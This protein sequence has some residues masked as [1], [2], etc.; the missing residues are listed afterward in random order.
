M[1]NDELKPNQLVKTVYLNSPVMQIDQFNFSD[2]C[3]VI[4]HDQYG[5]LRRDSMDTNILRPLT[6]EELCR[7]KLLGDEL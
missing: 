6:D 7:I 3:L 1:R 5:Q 4:W 2:Q